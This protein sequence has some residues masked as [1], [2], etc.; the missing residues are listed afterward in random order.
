MGC[1]YSVPVAI[2]R[3]FEYVHP[4]SPHLLDDSIRPAQLS[5]QIYHL[6]MKE[7]NGLRTMRDSFGVQYASS[8]VPFEASLSSGGGGCFARTRMIL[9][10][11][12]NGKPIATLIQ[13]LSRSS[14]KIYVFKPSYQGQVPSKH[15]SDDGKPLFTWAEVKQESLSMQYIMKESD[16]T[17]YVADRVG[18]V[19]GP[20]QFKFSRNG[21]TCASMQ[22]D[23]GPNMFSRQVWDIKIAPGIDP[24]RILCFI[25]IVEALIEQ[26]ESS[27]RAAA[28][29]A[30]ASS[31]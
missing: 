4:Q 2:A 14:F 11:N 16:D 3:D 6:K 10:N 18:R 7:K 15:R 27:A 29:V 30:A 9:Q 31:V 28:M 17:V 24:C 5:G 20:K 8:G 22:L 12:K 1:E 21:K 23:P 26:E 13:M 25:A 19:H